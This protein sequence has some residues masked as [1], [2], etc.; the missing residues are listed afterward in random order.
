MVREIEKPELTKC[1]ICDTDFSLKDEGGI[2]GY[3][4]MLLTSFCPFCLSSV[5]DMSK[6]LLGIE[7]DED[8]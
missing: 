3:F 1:S 4:G 6:Q 5:L 2:Q 7:D 8:A